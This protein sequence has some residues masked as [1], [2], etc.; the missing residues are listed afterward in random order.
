MFLQIA[1]NYVQFAQKA[2]PSAIS[3]ADH[4][5]LRPTF[6]GMLDVPIITKEQVSARSFTKRG[7]SQRSPTP[8]PGRSGP[9]VTTDW[10]LRRRQL[11][12]QQYVAPLFSVKFVPV[13]ECVGT[14]VS[15]RCAIVL[16][17]AS[18]SH[19]LPLTL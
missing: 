10:F 13:I 3:H 4:Q 18:A 11:R 8:P 15:V 5:I 7:C 16:S 1:R 6:V 2:L 17:Q 12:L 14:L 9:S 19:T